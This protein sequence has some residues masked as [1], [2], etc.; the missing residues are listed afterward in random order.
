MGRTALA[1]FG[2]SGAPPSFFPSNRS[3]DHLDGRLQ[4]IPFFALLSSSVQLLR[5][6]LR[7]LPL[8]SRFFD[9]PLSSNAHS[10]EDPTDDVISF[11]PSVGF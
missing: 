6:T 8:P 7:E 10:V 5:R 11:Y 2:N 3:A 9:S 4:W 1:A